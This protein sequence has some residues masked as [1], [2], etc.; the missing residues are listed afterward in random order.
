LCEQYQNPK[1]SSGE[2]VGWRC[3]AKVS[4]NGSF[5]FLVRQSRKIR[6]KAMGTYNARSLFSDVAKTGIPSD[7]PE[8]IWKVFMS[9]TLR[10]V[11]GKAF[12]S[13]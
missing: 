10:N 4:F 12:Y 5:S 3:V 8:K 9:S 1:S 2:V 11:L 13:W 7:Q 6:K